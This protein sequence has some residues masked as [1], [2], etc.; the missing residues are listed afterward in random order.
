MRKINKSFALLLVCCLIASLLTAF[1]APQKTYEDARRSWAWAT[2]KQWLD[3]GWLHGYADGMLRPEQPISRAEYAAIVNRA[4][5]LSETS[6]VSY[7]D[8]KASD[9]YYDDIAKAVKAG[10]V[11]GF[12][13]GS[14]K[15]GQAVNRQEAALILATFLRLDLSRDDVA[16]FG[17][18]ADIDDAS[19]GAVAVLLAQNLIQGFPDG[20]FRPKKPM[21]RAS[22]IVMI[23]AA[24]RSGMAAP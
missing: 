19:W 24:V 4:F 7:S 23:D 11:I 18:A 2:L 6:S 10:Y 12:E 5:G 22:A 15:P 17:D 13:D 16:R 21:T 1:T 9:W 14:F 3:N 8:V 20:T